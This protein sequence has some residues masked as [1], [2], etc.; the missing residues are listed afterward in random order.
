MISRVAVLG[1]GTMGSQIAGLMADRGILCDLFDL[2]MDGEP[3]ELA[4]TAIDRLREL[5]PAP[6]SDTNSLRLITPANF[7]DDLGRLANADWVI[8][9]V[10][11]D[12]SI[13]QSIWKKAAKHVR[14]D[15]IISTNTSGIPVSSIAGALPLEL[16]SR[17]LGAHFC[18]PPRYLP[19]L[20]LI[21]TADTDYRVAK[22]VSQVAASKL[23]R[24]V[25]PAHDVSNFIANTIGAFALMAIIHAAE[26]FGLGPDQVDSITGPIMGRPV[27]ATFRTLDVVGIDVFVAVVDNSRKASTSEE[28]R[29]ILNVPDYMRELVKRGW[30][31]QKAG[32]GFYQR[33]KT[34]QGRE[35]LTLDLETLEYKPRLGLE[36]SIPTNST[37]I[38]DP[39]KKIALLSS[40]EGVV[41]DFVWR[42]LSQMMVYSSEKLGLVADNIV[43]IDR[44]MRWGYA[45]ELGPFE[46]WDAIGLNQSLPRLNSDDLKVPEWVADIGENGGSFYRDGSNGKLQATLSGNYVPVDLATIPE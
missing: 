16:R 17:F 20:E 23:S 36:F 41:G 4:Q 45:W 27:S 37:A 28:E 14:P 18:N 43:S 32:Q 29:Q 1:A 11:E 42:I 46:T 5:K 7:E 31:G 33:I 44:A 9:A 6:V 38:S 10:S 34:D 40:L 35:I 26:E 3:N 21:S 2:K 22:T 25:V 8:E 13:K 39:Y 19:L 24:G 15:A 12:I 30:T